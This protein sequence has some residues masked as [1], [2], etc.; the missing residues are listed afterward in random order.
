MKLPRVSL[1]DWRAILLAEQTFASRTS[2]RG[3]G[4]QRRAGN[5][6]EG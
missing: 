5:L 4:V 2:A 3:V 6:K 1:Q